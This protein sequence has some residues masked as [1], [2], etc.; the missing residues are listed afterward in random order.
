MTS[1][2]VTVKKKKQQHNNLVTKFD[3]SLNK[4]KKLNLIIV[5]KNKILDPEDSNVKHYLLQSNKI[6]LI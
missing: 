3:G 5:R 4:I 6:R 2:K 1:M